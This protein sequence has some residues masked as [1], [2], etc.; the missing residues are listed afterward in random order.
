MA[1]LGSY[2]VQSFI[3]A[4]IMSTFQL[5]GQ[6]FVD[7]ASFWSLMFFALALS[8][9]FGYFTLGWAASAV[10]VVRK[11]Q[12]NASYID[13]S[14]PR[15]SMSQARIDSNTSRASSINQ[16]PST[17]SQKTRREP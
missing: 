1:E 15:C 17:M 12:S 10:S 11:T 9:A 13:L 7:R 3:F 4:N 8:A 5:V 6:E 16:Y 2:A 14:D